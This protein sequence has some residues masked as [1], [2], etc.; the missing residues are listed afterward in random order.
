VDLFAGRPIDAADATSRP[1]PCRFVSFAAHYAGSVAQ[2]AASLRPG[3]VVHDTFAVI[4]PVVANALAL[5]RVAVCAGHNAPPGPAVEALRTDPRV[6][7]SDACWRAV[8]ALRE[9][10]GM[11]DASPF[12]YMSTLSR[13]LNLYCEPPQFLRAEE[14]EP[15]QPIA[16]LG[17]LCPEASEA[18]SSARPAFAEGARER[19]RIY[20]SFGT[21]IWR[22]FE[23]EALAALEALAA[24]LAGRDDAV[25]L[26]SLGGRGTP[27]TAARLAGRNLRVESYVDQWQVLREASVFLTHQGL[28]STHEAIFHGTPMLSY[29]FFGDQPALARRCQELGLALPLVAGVRAPVTR[30]DLDAA[31]ARIASE[32]TRV[33][34][35][36]AEARRWELETIA[37]RGA[38]IERIVA[39]LERGAPG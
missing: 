16:F 3:L 30:A 15:F 22:Y 21:V 17:S 9:Q 10:H 37:A 7:V 13:D 38:L 4:G 26:V 31:L 33:Q 6:D 28:N 36:L 34:A 12:S 1:V 18:A 20:A 19:L 2:Q 14:R 5:P 23:K 25:A 11:P 8:R 35:R 29:P 24:A 27:E 32:R 39:L